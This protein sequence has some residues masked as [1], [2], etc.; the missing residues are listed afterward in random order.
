MVR[1]TPA[2][3]KGEGVIVLEVISFGEYLGEA[4]A[5]QRPGESIAA[6]HV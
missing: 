2:L 3:F 4:I 1:L 5:K 6:F